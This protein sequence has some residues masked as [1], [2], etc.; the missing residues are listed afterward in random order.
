MKRFV[1]RLQRVLEIK[2]KEEEKKRSELLEITEKLAQTRADLIA[3]QRLIED[4]I[5]EITRENPK[6][7]LDKQEFFFRYS[8]TSNEQIK[9]L[10]SRIY[11]LESQQR[12]K[13]DE[14][15]KT[16]RFK[17]GL[18]RLRV[19]A[20]MRFIKEQERLEQK[21]LDD[22][23]TVSFAREMIPCEDSCVMQ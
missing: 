20:K 10:K 9:K 4:M 6:K 1:W 19:E 23:A 8:K 12:R 2:A 16:R 21:E 15:L 17:E 13:I 7:R 11:E 3:K 14:L 18:E 22:G 5:L